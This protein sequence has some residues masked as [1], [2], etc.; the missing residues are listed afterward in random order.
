MSEV[1]TL[2][3]VSFKERKFVPICLQTRNGPCP[4]LAM[5][6]ILSL[7]QQLKLDQSKVRQS[8]LP[9]EREL[10]AY[11]NSSSL[12]PFDIS[13][14]R[15][16]LTSRDLLDIIGGYLLDRN[17]DI[18]DKKD[19]VSAN[20]ISGIGRADNEINPPERGG[21]VNSGY[22]RIHVRKIIL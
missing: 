11:S 20:Q 14:A 13:L 5:F 8:F 7:R 16:F 17:K 1:Y 18:F 4:L 10:S 2:K 15:G 22:V 3:R 12:F 6:N 9:L 21:S 19:G